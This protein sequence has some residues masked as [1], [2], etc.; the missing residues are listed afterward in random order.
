[1]TRKQIPARFREELSNNPSCLTICL[2]RKGCS[3]QSPVVFEPRQARPQPGA[4]VAPPRA[5][6][7]T[8]TTSVCV[9]SSASVI[10]TTGMEIGR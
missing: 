8:Q 7:L 4:V 1:M 6:G 5:V 3:R 9:S 2:L 10:P